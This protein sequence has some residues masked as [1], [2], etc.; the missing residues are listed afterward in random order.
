V[1]RHKMFGKMIGVKYAEGFISQKKIGL[2]NF[3]ALIKENT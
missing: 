1:Y 3:D 2:R